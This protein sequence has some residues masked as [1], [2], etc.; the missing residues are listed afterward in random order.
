M[1]PHPLVIPVF[2]P[3]QGCPHRCIFCDQTTITQTNENPFVGTELISRALEIYQ[4]HGRSDDRPVEIAFYGGNFLGLP[5]KK[6]MELLTA[7]VMWI[8]EGRVDSIRFSTRP[9]TIDEQRMKLI[10]PFPV[11]TIEIGAQSMDDGVLKASERGHCVEDIVR[12]VAQL[13]EGRYRIGIQLMVGLPGE[14]AQTVEMTSAA[15]CDLAPDFVRIYPTLVLANS[16]LA[17]AYREGQYNPLTLDEAVER[18][19]SLAAQF[20]KKGIAVIRMGLPADVVAEPDQLLAGPYHPAF[21]HLVY[22]RLY[23]KA[24]EKLLN[25]SGSLNAV[26]I[27]IHPKGV[28]TLRGLNNGNIAKLNECF[29]LTSLSVLSDATLGRYEVA[30]GDRCR[31]ILDVS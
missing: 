2:I 30:I 15:V 5:Q 8:D 21:G 26:T 22:E 16:G 24:T 9:D 10:T 31:S 4:P 29:H 27:S 3:H 6:I 7:S 28:S 14:T 12:A 20:L 11:K 13:K 17:K 19:A 23:F 1:K 18:T 25:A